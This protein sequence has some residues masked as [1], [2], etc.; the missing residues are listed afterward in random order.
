[1]NSCITFL[2]GLEQYGPYLH[3]PLNFPPYERLYVK[4]PLTVHCS[5]FGVPLCRVIGTEVTA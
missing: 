4:Q 2:L 5:S 3:K 1:M